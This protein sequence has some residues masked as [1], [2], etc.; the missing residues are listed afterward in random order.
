[1]KFLI[2]SLLFINVLVA[3]TLSVG[4]KYPSFM[5]PDQFNKFTKV[6][7]HDEM[8]IM[9]FEK[10]VSAELNLYLQDRKNDYLMSKKTKYVADISGMP[11]I[12]T[13]IF[14]LPKMKKYNYKIQL[15]H[16]EEQGAQFPRKD[17]M[18]TVFKVNNYKIESI[19][20]MKPKE[21]IDLLD[22]Q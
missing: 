6:Y 3:Q 22:K 16:S 5:I 7:H 8:V 1:M 9:T 18:I 4:D 15:I 20:Y 14:A 12:I 17:E 2:A 10:D 13:K 21:V 11:S 19:K